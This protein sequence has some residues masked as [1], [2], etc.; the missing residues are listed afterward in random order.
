MKRKVAFAALALAATV[1]GPLASGA[2]AAPPGTAPVGPATMTPTTGTGATSFQLKPIG[3][4]AADP[5][6]AYCPGD[7]ANDGYRVQTF[8]TPATVDPATLTYDVSGPIVPAA[9]SAQQPYTW[10][11][12]H[13]TTQQQW[14]NGTT[15]VNPKG[16]ID[17]TAYPFGFDILSGLLPTGDYL[18]GIACSKN[19]VTETFWEVPIT[20]TADGA[21]YTVAPNDGPDPV[22]PEAPLSVLLP[23]TGLGAVGAFLFFRRRNAAAQAA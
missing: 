21:G 2:S 13:P 17:P 5:A 12:F 9:D 1:S 18:V 20:I 6:N 23:L 22:V 3:G 19:G 11:L 10:S 14:L 15:A 16:F 4:N 7:S 8:L